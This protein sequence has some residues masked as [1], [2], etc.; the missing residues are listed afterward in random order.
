MAVEERLSVDMDHLLSRF[1]GES[2]VL[3]RLL[4]VDDAFRNVCEDYSLAETTLAKLERFQ[5]PRELP[6]IAE[7]RQ[8]IL[9]LASEIAKAIESAKRMQ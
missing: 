5:G 7:Y 3:T 4:A 9:E 8:L 1:P 6:R 2:A